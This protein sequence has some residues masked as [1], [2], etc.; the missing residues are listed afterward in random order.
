MKRDEEGK[1]FAHMQHILIYHES[2]LSDPV[3]NSAFHKAL[4][5]HV[6][7]GAAVLD[8]GSGTG[9][10]A[11]AAAKLGAARVVAIEKEK[12]LIPIIER[13]IS[14]NGVQDRVKVIEG[15]SRESRISGKFDVIISET[16]GNE[17][18]DEEIVPIMIDARK[19][20]L[21]KGGV[22]IPSSIASVL[23]PA[24]LDKWCEVLPASVNLDYNYVEQ[25]VL[26]I[27][28]RIHD[29]SRLKLLANPVALARVD[30]TSVEAPPMLTEMTAGWKLKDAS[31]LNCLVLWAEAVLTKGVALETI[32]STNWTPTGLPVEPF[33][34]GPAVIECTLTV[35]PDKHYSW[36][37][38]HTRNGK[39]Q[40]QSHSPIFPYTSLKAH[41]PAK[42]GQ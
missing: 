41:L 5:K 18:F 11:I 10:W 13:L 30:L 20:F 42:V 35:S 8:I 26:D 21:K 34:E 36:T 24:H 25:L 2:M 37:L 39:S 31:K 3:R 33:E 1:L 38:T 32:N 28:K 23:A 7:N 29:R 22:V 14:H 19:R 12:L 16:I 27:P 6:G 40:V 4:K 17:A 9:L 15:D